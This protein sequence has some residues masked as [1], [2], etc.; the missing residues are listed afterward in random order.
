MIFRGIISRMWI[1]LTLISAALFAVVNIFDKI[2][3]NKW[4][5][6]PFVPAIVVGVINIMVAGFIF[7]F[8]S[9][10]HFSGINILLAIVVGFLGF[11]STITYYKAVQLDDISRVAPLFQLEPLFV[12][13]LAAVFLG[14]VF[15]VS[16]YIGVFMLVLGALTISLKS[17]RSLKLGKSFWLMVLTGFII[18]I[19]L[20]MYKRLLDYGDFWTV[21]AYSRIGMIPVL[22]FIVYKS[23]KNLLDTVK[24]H[25][26]RCLFLMTAGES[27]GVVAMFFSIAAFAVGTATLVNALGSVQPLF[28]LFF[29]IILSLFL[30]RIFSEEIKKGVLLQ[31]VL[32]VAL[33][34]VG[35]LLV[36]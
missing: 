2:V 19:S 29:S 28:L 20:V 8:H 4:V 31:K 26:K 21:F 12:V 9:V 5:K 32:A 33:L 22:I 36:V 6:D 11:L 10:P 24:C 30:P 34:I 35:G 15:S 14:E 7:L 17:F 3:L 16:K 13:V 18:S 1:V 23:F 25:G 27:L